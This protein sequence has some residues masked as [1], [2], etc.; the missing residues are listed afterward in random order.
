MPLGNISTVIDM[1]D[2]DRGSDPIELVSGQIV[3]N[4]NFGIDTLGKIVQI[5][6]ATTKKGMQQEILLDS[7]VRENY[8]DGGLWWMMDQFRPVR[9]ELLQ[10]FAR[11]RGKQLQWAAANNQQ[12]QRYLLEFK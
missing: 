4:P 1:M 8:P 12:S 9:W 2:Q 5:R 11:L 7:Y 3:Y 10:D 6:G